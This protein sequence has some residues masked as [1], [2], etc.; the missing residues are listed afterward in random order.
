M[1]ALSRLMKANRRAQWGKGLTVVYRARSGRL[2]CI[3]LANAE[4]VAHFVRCAETPGSATSE[5]VA[6]ILTVW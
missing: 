2:V 4:R 3:T 1:N 6:K 5:G